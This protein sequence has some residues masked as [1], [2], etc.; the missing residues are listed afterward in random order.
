MTEVI[1]VRKI[2]RCDLLNILEVT[3]IENFTG[4]DWADVLE[5]EVQ[6]DFYNALSSHAIVLILKQ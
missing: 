6:S 2:F 1:V 3:I 5:M 4:N